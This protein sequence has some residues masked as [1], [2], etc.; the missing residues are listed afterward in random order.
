M[1]MASPSLRNF[2]GRIPWGRWIAL[3]FVAVAGSLFYGGSLGLVLTDWRI[4][5]AAVWL[6]LSAGLAW[7]IL[8]PVL[9]RFG[10]VELVPC[11][12]ACLVTMATGEIVLTVGAIVNGLLW[13]SGVVAHAVALNFVIVGISNVV[14][15]HILVRRLRPYGMTPAQVWT[16]WMLAL[17]GSGAVFFLTL[18]QWLH[19]A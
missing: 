4:S 10:K 12:D 3:L 16:A 14:M 8:I 6:A 1:E 17:N 2:V 15:A 9:W 7:C 11:L 19:R 18:Y 13:S 5:S